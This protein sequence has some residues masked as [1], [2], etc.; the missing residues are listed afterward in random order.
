VAAAYCADQ[1]GEWE[2]YANALMS[3]RGTAEAASA[4]RRVAAIYSEGI[5][6]DPTNED[7]LIRCARVHASLG[8]VLRDTGKPKEAEE[9]YDRARRFLEARAT[10]FPERT[11]YRHELGRIHNHLGLL[12]AEI[13]RGSEAEKAHRQAADIYEKLAQATLTTDRERWRRQELMWSHENLGRLAANSG[14]PTEGAKAYRQAI[15]LSEQLN[16]D[17]PNEYTGWLANDYGKLA[18]ILS[19][20]G[21]PEE[22]GK[23]YRKGIQLDPTNVDLLMSRARMYARLQQWPE[24]VADC[25]R[26]IELKPDLTEAWRIRDDAYR[27]QGRLDGALADYEK[28]VALLGKAA[29]QSPYVT[30]Q[31]RGLATAL[32]H[33]ADGLKAK[34]RL[35]DA[36]KSFRQAV[37]TWRKLATEF[38]KEP[39]NRVELG[40]SLWWLSDTLRSLGKRDEAEHQLRE[41]AEVFRTLAANFPHEPYYQRELGHT[42][43]ACLVPLLSGDPT[44]RRDLEEAYRQSLS[45][46]QK[47][48]TDF[49]TR[50]SEYP[51]WLGSNY[52]ALMNLLKTSARPQ[53]AVEL[54]RQAIDFYDKLAAKQPNDPNVKLELAKRYASLGGVLDQLGLELL[55]Q[56]KWAE[57]EPLLRECVT[58]R[59]E[60]QPDA[61]NTFNAQSMLGAAL[62]G[63]KKYTEAEPLLLKGYQEM[64]ARE[65]TIPPQG[66]IRLPEALDRLIELY[67]PTNKPDEVK[68][69]RAERAKYPSNKK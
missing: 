68:K 30:A 31:R 51:R 3:V 13:G 50:D 53:E 55:E 15:A 17:F 21:Q 49:P 35:A 40:H 52:E 19:A 27:R 23:A 69:W 34:G 25:T 39:S 32:Y 26:A 10:Q 38:P 1:A 41:A 6:L 47:L 64:K 42:W 60:A 43:S 8:D 14:Q 66:K 11:E 58:I 61:W 16:S 56:K 36:E 46:Y 33:L 20:N 37:V 22:A 62:L 24:T 63:Q 59:E 54:G 67:T 4:Y 48:V 7:L 29:S 9:V 5:Q 65:K 12:L 2:W 44:R 18:M 57:A 28:A 45:A